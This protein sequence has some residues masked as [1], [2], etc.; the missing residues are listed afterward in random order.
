MVA[1]DPGTRIHGLTCDCLFAQEEKYVDGTWVPLQDDRPGTCLG[2]GDSQGFYL[3]GR[4]VPPSPFAGCD[5]V[6]CSPMVAGAQIGDAVEFVVT[7]TQAPPAEYVNVAPATVITLESRPVHGRIRTHVR[8]FEE[9]NCG[10]EYEH[11]VV[12]EVSVP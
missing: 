2:R 11:E 10:H 6:M 8:Y 9:S 1:L 3:D 12:L 7:G 4:F 5:S